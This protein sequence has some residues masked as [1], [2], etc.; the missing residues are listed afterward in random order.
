MKQ[1]YP[2]A[3]ELEIG[4]ADKTLSWR[5]MIGWYFQIGNDSCMCAPWMNE[6]QFT[7]KASNQFSNYGNHKLVLL[8]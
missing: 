4:Y 8:H 5:F 3:F 2:Y 7:S 6:S 1:G